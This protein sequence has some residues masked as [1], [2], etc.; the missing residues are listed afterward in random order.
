[1]IY[2]VTFSRQRWSSFCWDCMSPLMSEI[3]THQSHPHY[4]LG[5]CWTRWGC[6]QHPPTQY[7]SGSSPLLPAQHVC[8]RGGAWVCAGWRHRGAYQSHRHTVPLSSHQAGLSWA[9]KEVALP[10]RQTALFISRGTDIRELF[11]SPWSPSS[12]VFYIRRTT[13]IRL[14]Y[15]SVFWSFNH[16]F[17]NQQ[18]C[19]TSAPSPGGILISGDSQ[20][21]WMLPPWKTLGTSLHATAL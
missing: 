3:G 11:N 4:D 9:R 5:Q 16:A 14:V 6:A 8:G 10:H 12:L 1:M 17:T 13:F 20:W 19:R 15:I 18:T 7:A 21:C 2:T